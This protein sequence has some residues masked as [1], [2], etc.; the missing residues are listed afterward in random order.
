MTRAQPLV[1]VEPL[2]T[3]HDWLQCPACERWVKV[4]YVPTDDPTPRCS[5]CLSQVSTGSVP[6]GRA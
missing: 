3:Q 6:G 1:D 5:H 4:L 2:E